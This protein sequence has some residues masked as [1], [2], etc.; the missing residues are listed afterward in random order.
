M[1]N[2]PQMDAED[3]RRLE[4]L[5]FE[6]S[7]SEQAVRAA[8]QRLPYG[9][10]ELD[11]D[12]GARQT[13]LEDDDARDRLQG[14]ENAGRRRQLS[15]DP[16]ERIQGI[17]ERDDAA[18]RRLGLDRQRAT[19]PGAR[20]RIDSEIE[21]NRSQEQREIEKAVEDALKKGGRGAATE[22]GATAEGI[23]RG[24]ADVGSVLSDT[25][26]PILDEV[27]R[28]KRQVSDIESRQNNR[29]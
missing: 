18:R 9:L 1:L 14:E 17:R 8:R 19:G 11:V 24:L 2:T 28:L 6:N 27:G 20:S 16:R 15:S 25:L 5:A 29:A 7:L 26:V 13:R 10:R 21:L 22:M 4:R 12:S 3:Y 23:R